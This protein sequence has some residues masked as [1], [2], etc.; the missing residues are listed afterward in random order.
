MVNAIVQSISFIDR[1]L[2]VLAFA[3]EMANWLMRI[4]FVSQILEYHN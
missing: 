2:D 3:I 4:K 1:K